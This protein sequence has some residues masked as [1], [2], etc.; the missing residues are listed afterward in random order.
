MCAEVTLPNGHTLW[1][2][3]EL[4]DHGAVVTP[5]DLDGTEWD[6]CFCCADPGP[7][8]ERS[9]WTYDYDEVFGDYHISPLPVFR[10]MAGGAV[11]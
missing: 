5:E 7:V 9:G 2:L 3:R 1:N 4:A 10:L 11:R 6:W 8:L